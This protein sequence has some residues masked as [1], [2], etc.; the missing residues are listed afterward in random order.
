MI[1]SE[2]LESDLWENLDKFW[3]TWNFLMDRELLTVTR[4][5]IMGRY[6]SLSGFHGSLLTIFTQHCPARLGLYSLIKMRYVCHNKNNCPLSVIYFLSSFFSLFISGENGADI[7]NIYWCNDA[8][9]IDRVTWSRVIHLILYICTVIK[10]WELWLVGPEEMPIWRAW[11]RSSAKCALVFLEASQ[12]TQIIPLPVVKIRS[13]VHLRAMLSQGKFNV[14]SCS[15]PGLSL[16]S[17]KLVSDAK[18]HFFIKG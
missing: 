6:S 12:S 18:H 4:V 16:S 15:L 14:L 10:S 1:V 13:Q 11:V 2:V 8:T 5:Q 3:V 9:I 7:W 17:S